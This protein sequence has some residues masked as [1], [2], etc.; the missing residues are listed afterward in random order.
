MTSD[1]GCPVGRIGFEGSELIEITIERETI[2][3][4]EFLQ[5]VLQRA[6]RHSQDAVALSFCG[7]WIPA[8]D[9]AVCLRGN[10]RP[11]SVKVPKAS[12]LKQI[13][14][15]YDLSPTEPEENLPQIF[16]SHI[17]LLLRWGP[18]RT[19][20]AFGDPFIWLVRYSS[21]CVKPG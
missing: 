19:P 2:S 9:W 8:S 14:R 4:T 1:S 10:V 12:P 13:L 18:T 5:E 6:T 17:F 3:N 7:S 20:P 21:H 15:W 11:S 16:S